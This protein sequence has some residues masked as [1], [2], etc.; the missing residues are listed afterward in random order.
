MASLRNRR[1][2]LAVRE[3]ADGILRNLA[4]RKISWILG[5][6]EWCACGN[7]HFSVERA[8]DCMWQAVKTD[9]RQIYFYPLR[10]V[11]ALRM[12]ASF[13][14]Q[15][16]GRRQMLLLRGASYQNQ[17]VLLGGW[18]SVYPFRTVWLGCD[19]DHFRLK[20]NFGKKFGAS[21]PSFFCWN[22][23]HQSPVITFRLI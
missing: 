11:F 17:R 3:V 18:H 21:F 5:R 4:L 8:Y 14:T 20:Q 13:G 1:L 9:I 15:T 10:L 6:E 16:K 19:S 23:R 12:V 7:S 22:R 2:T